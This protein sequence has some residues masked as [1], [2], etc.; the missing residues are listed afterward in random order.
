MS[1]VAIAHYLVVELSTLVATYIKSTQLLALHSKGS[2]LHI[3]SF[4][5]LVEIHEDTNRGIERCQVFSV[6]EFKCYYIGLS[7]FD[8]ILGFNPT[9]PNVYC[10][11]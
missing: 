8:K 4:G 5:A 6:V 10:L 7:M 1:S 9:K 2:G 11:H 3:L